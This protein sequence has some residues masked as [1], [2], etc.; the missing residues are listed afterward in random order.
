[1][2]VSLSAVLNFLNLNFMS[3]NLYR[4]AIVLHRAKLYI[5]RLLAYVQK[6]FSTWG[7]SPSRIVKIFIFWSR[8]CR[9]VLVYN[10]SWVNMNLNA[11]F[12][13]DRPSRLAVYKEYTDC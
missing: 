12:G 3:R 10:T 4:Y 7:R 1:M 8:D 13:P 5:N 11:K 6:L 2:M 9:W